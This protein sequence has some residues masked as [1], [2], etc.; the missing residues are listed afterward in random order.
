MSNVLEN[1]G[2]SNDLLKVWKI[3]YR[4]E[5]LN[6]D[7]SNSSPIRKNNGKTIEVYIYITKRGYFYF[8]AK[9]A[10]RKDSRKGKAGGM[11]CI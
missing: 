1:N 5:Y 11:W 4:V 3:K 10:A 9:W 2:K 6:Y 8:A 7:Y